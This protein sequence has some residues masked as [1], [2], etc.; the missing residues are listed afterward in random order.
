MLEGRER[1]E[2]GIGARDLVKGISLS[3][4]EGDTVARDSER[5]G[6]RLGHACSVRHRMWWVSDDGWLFGSHKHEGMNL[7]R[8]PRSVGELYWSF[9]RCGSEDH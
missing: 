8:K 3:G 4:V 5:V 1:R 6:G 2:E 9:L 7:P